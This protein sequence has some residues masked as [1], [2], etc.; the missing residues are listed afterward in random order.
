MPENKSQNGMTL[1]E[2][3][4]TIVI[5]G[6]VASGVYNLFRVHNLMAAK[7]DETTRMQQELLSSIAQIADDLRM[8]GY[9]DSGTNLGFNATATNTTA[10]LCT[11]DPTSSAN[12]TEIGYR[13]NATEN[14]IEYL[15]P[16]NSTWT[17]SAEDISELLF[18]YYDKDGTLITPA[19][20]TVNNIR[21]IEVSITAIAS[22]QRIALNIGNRTMTTRIYCRNMG[23]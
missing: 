13:H 4:I 23:I 9:S 18:T 11:K 10:V 12:Y 21:Y 14:I 2:L 1:V 7:Q 19:A 6:I 20:N 15:L 8:C 3:L 17:A 5:I 16:T 22:P